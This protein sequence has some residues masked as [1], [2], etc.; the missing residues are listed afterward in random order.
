MRD[1]ASISN[2]DLSCA[3]DYIELLVRDNAALLAQVAPL[4]EF[5]EDIYLN[6]STCMPSAWNDETSWYKTQ[7]HG[8]IGKAARFAENWKGK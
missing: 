7:L 6:T 1:N 2:S 3:L 8:V 4:R 5:I